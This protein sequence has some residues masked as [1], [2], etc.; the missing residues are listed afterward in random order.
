MATLI[1]RADEGGDQQRVPC[2]LHALSVLKHA[3]QGGYEWIRVEKPG[4][5]CDFMVA[6]LIEQ[7]KRDPAA[8]PKCLVNLSRPE[9][10]S[11]GT[12]YEPRTP[13]WPGAALG[14]RLAER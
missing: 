4:H 8:A 6:A 3:R 10:E 7:A 2:H 1:L 5:R 11:L 14:R 9:S 13:V 12:R